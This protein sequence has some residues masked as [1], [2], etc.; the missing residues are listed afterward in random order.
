MSRTLQSIPGGTLHKLILLIAGIIF[1]CSI[2][3]A[4]HRAYLVP[5]SES[6]FVFDGVELKADSSLNFAEAMSKVPAA[7]ELARQ[8]ESYKKWSSILF[9][10]GAGLPL[11]Y[12]LSTPREDFSSGIYWGTFGAGMISS[13][14]LGVKS[15][16]RLNEAFDVYNGEQP[17]TSSSLLSPSLTFITS[18]NRKTYGLGLQWDF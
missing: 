8:H 13:I 17:Q 1:G 2:S 6:V 9:W 14:V 18:T 15:A 12:I 7:A 11:L 16:N 4:K 5:G 10:T 3:F